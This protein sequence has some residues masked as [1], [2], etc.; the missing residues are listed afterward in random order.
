MMTVFQEIVVESILPITK[1]NHM[2]L[3][4]F[5]SED[6]VSSDEIK[7]C[8]IFQFQSNEIERSAFFGGTP[9]IICIFALLDT[10]IHNSGSDIV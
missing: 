10:C 6:N 8:Y 4:S 7:V 1:P 2:I 5:L 3:V 9:G